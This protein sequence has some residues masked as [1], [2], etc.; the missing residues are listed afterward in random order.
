MTEKKHL[1]RPVVIFPK[2]QEKQRTIGFER[3]PVCDKR[4]IEIDGIAP[5]TNF[6]LWRSPWLQD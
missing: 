3:K 5:S 2:R 4:R 1:T 6:K